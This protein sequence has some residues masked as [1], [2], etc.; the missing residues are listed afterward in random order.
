MHRRTIVL[1]LP[2]LGLPL[3]GLPTGARA[4]HGWG[5]YAADQPTTLVGTVERVSFENP[6]GILIL[7][8]PEKV[9]EIV[10]APPFRMISRGL[11]ESRI[12]PGDTVEVMGYPH[13][14]RA[15][16]LRAEWIKVKGAIT[17]LR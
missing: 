4:H 6:H 10:L 17:Q 12:Q 7:K 9:W 16:E 5:S 2:L 3:L 15:I 11:E 8:T 14:T 1:A 13:R